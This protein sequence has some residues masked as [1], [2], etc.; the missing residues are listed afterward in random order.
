VTLTA[1]FEGA[2]APAQCTWQASRLGARFARAGAPVSLQFKEQPLKLVKASSSAG[3]NS[4]ALLTA[5]MQ[6]YGFDEF[7]RPQQVYLELAP[8]G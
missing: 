6:L 1:Q 7:G 5:T 2:P 4:T 8:G 3:C